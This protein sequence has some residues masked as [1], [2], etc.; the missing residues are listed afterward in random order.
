MEHRRETH[1]RRSIRLP[2]YDYAQPGA[3][4]VTI[5][6]YQ[7]VCIF[8]KVTHSRVQLSEI[9]KIVG[10]TWHEIPTHFPNVTNDHFV[11]MPNHIHGIIMI[12][13]T[14]VGARHASP[15]P[16]PHDANPRNVNH[17]ALGA[18][19]GSFKSVATKKIHQIK[20]FE[21]RPAWQRNYYEHV[22]RDEADFKNIVDYIAANPVNWER[23]PE[24]LSS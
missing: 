1:H 9:G 12:E 18:I 19:V 21:N 24:Y 17:S 5:V 3:Y 14:L 8:G 11:V 13:D 23:D 10:A 16:I 15:K 2:E 6:T 4:F 7:H 20:G 22:I